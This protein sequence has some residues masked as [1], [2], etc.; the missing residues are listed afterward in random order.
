[1]PKFIKLII[2]MKNYNNNTLKD[3]EIFQKT[4]IIKIIS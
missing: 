2:I 3:L 4:R 1:M